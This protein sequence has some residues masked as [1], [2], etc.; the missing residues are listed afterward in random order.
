MEDDSISV[1]IFKTFWL[2]K[3]IYSAFKTRLFQVSVTCE[4]R[5]KPLQK[6]LDTVN[7]NMNFGG[8]S[9]VLVL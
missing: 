8:M 7:S 6:L 2:E 4:S 9:V 1:L 3:Q 5:H